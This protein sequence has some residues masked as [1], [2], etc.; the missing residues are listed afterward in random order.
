MLCCLWFRH[1]SHTCFVLLFALSLPLPRP[2]DSLCHACW[3]A[4]PV[5]QHQRR[6]EHTSAHSSPSLS[7]EIGNEEPLGH[8][9]APQL[10]PQL[11]RCHRQLHELMRSAPTSNPSSTAGEQRKGA[12]GANRA[13]F[14][15]SIFSTSTTAFLQ[16]SL[17]ELPPPHTSLRTS[18]HPAGESRML[19]PVQLCPTRPC[20][21]LMSASLR[22]SSVV[23]TISSS[24][25]DFTAAAK[26]GARLQ[27]CGDESL[28]VATREGEDAN[29]GRGKGRD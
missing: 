7:S 18:P 26:I 22:N 20:T 9:H 17:R 12:A 25:A 14:T 19:N 10:L 6:L 8:E 2:S 11:R 4:S 29:A 21:A 27:L 3:S 23:Q 15:S 16:R 1:C 13:L 24:F 28:E 5:A